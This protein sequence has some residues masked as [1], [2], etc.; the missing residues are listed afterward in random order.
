MVFKISPENT[1][2]QRP[3][4]SDLPLSR[5]TFYDRDSAQ[6]CKSVLVPCQKISSLGSGFYEKIRG[7]PDSLKELFRRFFGSSE[8]LVFSDPTDASGISRDALLAISLLNT[9]LFQKK[10]FGSFIGCLLGGRSL[11]DSFRIW[12]SSGVSIACNDFDGGVITFSSKKQDGHLIFDLRKGGEHSRICFNQNIEVCDVFVG[13][14]QLD[15]QVVPSEWKERFER[16][17]GHLIFQEGFTMSQLGGGINVHPLALRLQ[18]IPILDR[19]RAAAQIPR[20]YFL[21]DRFRLMEGIDAGGPSR[22][23]FNDLSKGLFTGLSSRVF[24]IDSDTKIPVLNPRSADQRRVLENL[25]FLMGIFQEN[26]DRFCM[27]RALPDVYFGLLK[28]VIEE[29]DPISEDCVIDCGRCL[30][31]EENDWMWQVVLGRAITDPEK[32]L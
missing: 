4:S 13:G 11:L 15:S 29:G 30:R 12:R 18:P 27:G 24:N 2:F 8:P 20:I 6:G 32:L 16:V 21:D 17:M 7:I 22:Q 3:V 26:A 28:K 9:R 1:A 19:L 14:E 25:G 10:G 23:F 31:K 5:R